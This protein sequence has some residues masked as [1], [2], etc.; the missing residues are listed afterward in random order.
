MP[1]DPKF[2]RQHYASLSDEALRAINRADLVDAA[3]SCYDD[4]VKQRDLASRLRVRPP[5][6]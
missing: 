4:E 1:A 2:L 5:V 6:E 3:Q